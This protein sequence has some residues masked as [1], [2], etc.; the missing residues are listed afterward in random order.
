MTT[1]Y[2]IIV[3]MNP[4]AKKVFGLPEFWTVMSCRGLPLRDGLIT[5]K[6]GAFSKSSL[7]L[8]TKIIIF[9]GERARPGRVLV[10]YVDFYLHI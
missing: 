1:Q 10:R 4:V 9:C 5:M 7:L 3:P 8:R 6:G 2:S